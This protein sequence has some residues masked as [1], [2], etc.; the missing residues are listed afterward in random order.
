M[1]VILGP[2]LSDSRAN[3]VFHLT[4]QRIHSA[5]FSPRFRT[6]STLQRAVSPIS[7]MPFGPKDSYDP[8]Y[9][10]RGTKRPSR[11][12][13]SNID[14]DWALNFW[15]GLRDR[16]GRKTCR[17]PHLGPNAS[18]EI[19]QRFVVLITAVVNPIDRSSENTPKS[20]FTF[21][22]YWGLASRVTP[23][24]EPFPLQNSSPPSRSSRESMTPSQALFDSR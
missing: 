20:P 9:G 13:P 14:H 15:I 5:R 2:L 3:I 1:F 17:V 19:S 16:V 12:C 18:N 23:M 11:R 10:V 7:T 6:R 4:P 22:R 24:P 8:A 21:W